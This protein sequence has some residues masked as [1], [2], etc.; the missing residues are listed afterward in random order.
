MPDAIPARVLYAAADLL[1]A[2]DPV[3]PLLQWHVDIPKLEDRDI[4]TADYTLVVHTPALPADIPTSDQLIEYATRLRPKLDEWRLRLVSGF[5]T[6][7]LGIVEHENGTSGEVKM[8]LNPRA[9]YAFELFG[10][11]TG[12]GSMPPSEWLSRLV[13]VATQAVSS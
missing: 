3:V 8:F 10:T 11:H 12:A 9:A 7:E 5:Y 2:A 6:L 13:P 1:S 4:H